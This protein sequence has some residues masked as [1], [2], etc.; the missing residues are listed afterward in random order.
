VSAPPP[1]S[2]P[3]D[4]YQ[5]RRRGLSPIALIFGLILGLIG[6]LVIAWVVA[7]V[8]VVDVAPSQLNQDDQ[9]RFLEAVALAYAQDS[10]LDRAVRR[11]LDLQLPGDPIQVMA[12]TACRLATSGYVN[13]TSGLRAV[14]AMVSFYQLQGRTGCADQ[15]I[16][17]SAF[18]PTLVVDVVL[19][20]ATPTLIPP[21]TK[22]ATP[23]SSVLETATP[24]ALVFTPTPIPLQFDLANV[25]TACNA[26][27]P[28]VIEVLV[29]EANGSTGIPGQ[30]VRARWGD[31]DNLFVTGLQPGRNP[32]FADFVMNEGQSYLIDLPG[33]SPV[34]QPALTAAPCTDPT[35][36]ERSLITYR[37][38]F[39]AQG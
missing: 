20:T 27:S 7:P 34:V 12:D 36:G 19:P 8:Q 13:T 1:N 11:L 31:E 28:G 21:P 9:S 22:T 37:V 38:S 18:Q 16:S 15:V 32:G 33:Q 10:N 23:E 2:P 14:Q 17:A 25:A 5:R 39:R 26:A 30:V 4:R 6:G 35:T 3:S 29:Y 24:A